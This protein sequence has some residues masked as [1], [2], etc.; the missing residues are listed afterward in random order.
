MLIRKFSSVDMRIKLQL[1]ESLCMSFY[2]LEIIVWRKN[3]SAALRKLSVAYHY[4]LKRLLGFPKHSSNHYVCAILDKLTF[5]HFLNYKSVKFLFWLESCESP[6]FAVRKR[7]MIKHSM[8][9]GAISDIWY[10]EYDIINPLEND[11]DALLS[12]MFFIQ[13]REPSSWNNMFIF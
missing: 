10:K 7:Y 6:C 9:A 13:R 12:R 8:F 2:G 4:A 5:T 3:C 11:I 1:F